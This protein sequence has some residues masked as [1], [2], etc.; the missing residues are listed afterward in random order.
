[1]ISPFYCKIL[2]I[3]HRLS[4]IFYPQATYIKHYLLREIIPS[5]IDLQRNGDSVFFA[6]S[7]L[8][9]GASDYE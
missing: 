4:G 9:G 7:H 5:F 6:P 2:I 8:P 1:M 3:G